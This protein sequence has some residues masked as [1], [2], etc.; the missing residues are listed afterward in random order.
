MRKRMFYKPL[1]MMTLETTVSNVGLTCPGPSGAAFEC[2]SEERPS[3]EPTCTKRQSSVPS[4][5]ESR[6]GLAI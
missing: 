4:T 1:A 3:A 2:F 6:A 5:F